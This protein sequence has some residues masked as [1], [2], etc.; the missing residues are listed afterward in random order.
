MDV[1]AFATGSSVPQSDSPRWSETGP[2]GPSPRETLPT[3]YD[4]PSEFPEEPGLPDVFPRSTV[5]TDAEQER[6]A[7]E[8]ER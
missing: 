6:Q 8:Q 4:L 2:G 1:M 7:K 3:M 5:P